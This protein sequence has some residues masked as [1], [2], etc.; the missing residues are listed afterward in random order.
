MVFLLGCNIL[1]GRQIPKFQRNLLPPSSVLK[2]RQP[3][4]L[5]QLHLSTKLHG[6][7]SRGAVVF[8]TK[9]S[10]YLTVLPAWFAWKFIFIPP[11]CSII[12]FHILSDLRTWLWQLHTLVVF[13]G[14]IAVSFGIEYG[15]WVNFGTFLNLLM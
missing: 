5:K 3:V 8:I 6:V 7:T 10:P 12:I 15:V 13:I 4:P 14:G 2:W 9:R 1:F 11:S